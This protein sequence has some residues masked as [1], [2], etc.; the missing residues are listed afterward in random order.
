MGVIA[1]PVTPP[2]ASDVQCST[3]RLLIA[4]VTEVDGCQVMGKR[5]AIS[6]KQGQK[7]TIKWVMQDK[8][9]NPVDLGDC[10]TTCPAPASSSSSSSAS[11][12][13]SESSVAPAPTCHTV[14]LRIRESLSLGNSSIGDC[15]IAGRVTD[16]STGCVEF[17]LTTV[18]TAASGIFLG[19]AAMCDDAGDMLF[20][21]IFY[22]TIERGQFGAA[23]QLGGPPNLAEIRLHLRDNAAADNF[24]LDRI[25]FDEAEIALAITRPVMYWNDVP[26]PI[27]HH[28]TKTFPYRWA[29]LEGI[30]ANLFM[31]AAESYRRN[32]LKYQAAGLSIADK[33]KWNQYEN[34]ARARWMEY[35][36]WV[37]QTKLS[38]NLDMGF[39]SLGSTYGVIGSNLATNRF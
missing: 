22:I 4:D 12:E 8:D 15:E 9:G 35:Q 27:G 31:I 11:S 34:V 37:K 3:Q 13:S 6:V 21:N 18:T 38:L 26:P 32:D 14:K 17:D 7:A 25:D 29:W 5:Q 24:L 23:N 39:S 16:P 30:A 1:T 28:T 36:Q 10:A 20:S 33:D 19:E 2:P